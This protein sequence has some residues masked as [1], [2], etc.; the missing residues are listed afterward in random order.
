[1]AAEI[2]LR[3]ERIGRAYKE[4]DRELIILNDADFTLRRG[5]M[6]A[7]VAP[8]GAGKSTLLHTAGLLE[9]PDSGDVVLDG[10]SCSKLSD[11]E[12]TAVRRNDVGFVYQFHHLLPEFSAL[13][14][15]M[16]PQMIR[17]L[18]RKAAA[19][20]AQQLLEYMKIGKRASHRPAEL[21][22]GEQQRVAIARAVANAPLVL[23]ADEPTGN[24]DPTT[25]SYVFGALEALVRQSGLAALIATHNHELARRMDRRVTLK[26][27]RVVDL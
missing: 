9:R 13:E 20:H 6:V 26:D 10:R 4:A 16:L 1:M 23:L 15:V 2:I 11:D 5:E 14:N 12:R 3:L 17:G 21:S 8:S 7:L 24:L 25:S 27:G 22:G 19:E 18:S